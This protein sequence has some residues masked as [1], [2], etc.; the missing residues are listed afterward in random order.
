LDASDPYS[1]PLTQSW[2]DSTRVDVWDA[3]REQPAVEWRANCRPVSETDSTDAIDAV[4]AYYL[5]P[6]LPEGVRDTDAGEIAILDDSTGDWRVVDVVGRVPMIQADH[7][8][9]GSGNG[10]GTPAPSP[11]VMQNTTGTQTTSI[12]ANTWTQ[13]TGWSLDAAGATIGAITAGAVTV[14]AAHNGA[15]LSVRASVTWTATTV[16][17]RRA[18]AIYV[19]GVEH[20]RNDIPPGPGPAQSAGQITHEVTATFRVAT[21]DT[22][23]VQVWQNTTAALALLGSAGTPNRF[24]LVRLA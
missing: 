1:G 18:I 2:G 5:V 9:N 14:A 4:V 19:N 17:G 12:A 7:L 21:G 10:G 6:L 23:A 20:S 8:P 13:M 15:L 22:I 24:Q 16:G 3:G 11:V